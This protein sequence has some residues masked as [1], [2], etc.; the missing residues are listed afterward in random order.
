MMWYPHDVIYDVILAAPV[1]TC[2]QRGLP[3]LCHT[4]WLAHWQAA[5]LPLLC[6]GLVAS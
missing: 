4:V 1:V 5:T 3:D 6:T 2:R